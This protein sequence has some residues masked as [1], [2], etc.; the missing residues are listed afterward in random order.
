M[1]VILI[2]KIRTIF[3][4]NEGLT[5]I[6]NFYTQFWTKRKRRSPKAWFIISLY[7]PIFETTPKHAML[8]FLNDLKIYFTCISIKLIQHNTKGTSSS[9]SVL[10]VTCKFL[11]FK[12]TSRRSFSGLGF[13]AAVIILVLTYLE[14]K[15]CSMLSTF[16]NHYSTFTYN[17]M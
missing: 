15:Y 9:F 16:A 2:W 14:K 11:N 4:A 13:I 1:T 12:I 3:P 7:L 17:C 8:F 6:S 10:A 5:D